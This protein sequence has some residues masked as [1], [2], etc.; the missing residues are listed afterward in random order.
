MLTHRQWFL[1]HVA[2]T[3]EA[4][5][6]LEINRAE[7]IYLFS[8]DGKWY[9]DLIAGI[10]VSNI[11]HCHPKVVEAVQ[12]QAAAFMHLMVYGEYIHYPQVALARLLAELLPPSLSCVYFVNSGAE[13]TEAAMKLA[14]RATGRTDIVYCRHAYH[15]STQGALSIMGDEYF[16]SAFRPLLPA[17]HMIRYAHEADLDCIN[18]HTAAVVI[19]AVQA[20]AGVITASP[21][22]F[23][24]L[25]EIC[26]KTG[27]LLILDEIQTGLGRTGTLFAF[28]QLGIVP[29]ILLLG[30]AL[31]GGMPI[32]ALVSSKELMSLWKNNPVLGH[33]TTF[34]GHPVACAAAK[35]AL[36]VLLKNQIM[37]TVA[38]KELLFRKLLQHPAIKTIRSK[39][40]LIAIEWEDATMCRKI[41]DRCL[42][43]GVITDWFLFAPHCQRIAPPLVITHSE[44]EQACALILEAIHYV[45]R[46]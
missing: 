6:M 31:G 32:G 16:K 38:E 21:S 28:E 26:S 36:E 7:G 22:Y 24:K 30:K 45:C 18:K 3:S 11:G 12:R 41:I 27:A 42:E 29:D 8:P 44:I 37:E 9:F 19:E 34:G 20:E 23:Q 10:S 13:A 5:L 39:G 35:A 40:L 33:I 43:K 15:G 2:Q 1:S 14:K 17:V 25:R 4:P 46:S